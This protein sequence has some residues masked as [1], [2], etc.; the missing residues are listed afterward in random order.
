MAR[1]SV[2]RFIN[3][4]VRKRMSTPSVPDI[5]P[6]YEHLHDARLLGGEEFVP[7]RI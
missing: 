5:N 3:P 6:L 7:E 1:S 2:T 4:S